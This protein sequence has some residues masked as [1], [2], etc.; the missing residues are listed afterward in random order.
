MFFTD[1][2]TLDEI[3]TK[4]KGKICAL[5]FLNFTYF[6][7]LRYFLQKFNAANISFI[8]C[9]FKLAFPANTIFH[10]FLNF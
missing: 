1:N 2:V 9:C 5:P 4:I 6:K 10:K 7:F 8:S 3:P